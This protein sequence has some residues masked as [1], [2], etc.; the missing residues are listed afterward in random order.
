MSFTSLAIIKK[1]LL[2]TDV[3]ELQI[4]NMPVTLTGLGTINL[5]H[6]DLAPNREVVKWETVVLPLHDGPIVLS[7][8]GKAS[9]S[10]GNIVH[11][12]VVV[13]LGETLS[14]VYVEETDYKLDYL[15]GSLHRVPTGGIPNNQPVHVYYNRYLI[16]NP[17]SDY[18]MDYVNG[19]IARHSGS[20]IPDGATVLIDYAVVAGSVTDDLISQAVVEA[21]DLIVRSL[22]SAYSS[23]SPDQGLKTGATFLALSIIAR[24]MTAESLAR[25]LGS[26]SGSRAK[27]WQNLSILYEARAWETLRPFVETFPIHSVQRR[28]N[29]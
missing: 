28:P 19:T 25:R 5:P 15:T 16:F 17:G 23:S 22:S 27:E 9:L 1:H 11:G 29:A 2:S 14:T 21:E 13:T 8:G 10:S 6:Q 20:T 7:D 18:V 12:S 3:G 24:D 4:E 26:D